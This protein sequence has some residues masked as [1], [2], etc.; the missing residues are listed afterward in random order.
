MLRATTAFAM[1]ATIVA[2]FWLYH[3]S[4]EV[5]RLESHVTAEERRLERLQSEVAVLQAERA[6][7]T[8]PARIEPL[9]RLMGLRPATPDQLAIV[10]PA[11]RR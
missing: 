9:A 7:L 3:Q 4:Y 10:K 1:A 11:D 6:F 5:R 8:R 2:A